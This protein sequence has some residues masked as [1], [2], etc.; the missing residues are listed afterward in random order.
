MVHGQQPEARFLEN[1]RRQRRVER[2]NQGMTWNV[3]NIISTAADMS[4]QFDPI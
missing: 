4:N 2:A 3:Q 1:V